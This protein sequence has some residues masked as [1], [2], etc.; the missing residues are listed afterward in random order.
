MSEQKV[1]QGWRM[2]QLKDGFT[3]TKKPRGLRY[4]DFKE[5][6]FV[7]MELIPFGELSFNDYVLKSP[8]QFSPFASAPTISLFPFLPISPES[9][10]IPP[11]IRM[12]T[13]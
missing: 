8:E 13:R 3:F 5:V 4:S 12:P 6:P 10:R 11:G 1:P 2:V 7:P 9:Y